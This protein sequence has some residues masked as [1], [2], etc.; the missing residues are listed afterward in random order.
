M[1]G[2]INTYTNDIECDWAEAWA[3]RVSHYGLRANLDRQGVASERFWDNFNGWSEWQKNNNY[4]GRLL[5]R[6]IQFVAPDDRILEIGAGSGAFAIPLARVCKMVTAVEPSPGQVTRL[7]ENAF[8][9]GGEES[10][11]CR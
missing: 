9:E 2:A 11:G 7:N 4:P 3:N 8:R 1:K 5:E 10:G 6:I